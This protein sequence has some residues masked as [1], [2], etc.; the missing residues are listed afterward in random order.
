MDEQLHDRRPER[1][2]AAPGRDTDSKADHEP[3]LLDEPVLPLFGLSGAT[4][5][6]VFLGG[7]LGTLARYELAAHHPTAAGAFPWVTLLVNLTGSFA[8]GLLVPVTERIS[9]RAPSLRPLLMVGFLGG[10]TTYST[11]AV[12]ATLLGKD[13]DLLTSLAYL[14]ATV[15]GG[16]ALVV[17]GHALGR[18]AAAR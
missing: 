2:M 5:A 14:V 4:I 9:R 13:G 11:L 8:I 1:A 17:A 18:S 7:A 6:A 10:W 15:V 3:D 12:D 16:L